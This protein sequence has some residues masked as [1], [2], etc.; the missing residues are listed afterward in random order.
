MY[1]DIKLTG[2]HFQVTQRRRRDRVDW[3]RRH[4]SVGGGPRTARRAVRPAVG[5][6]LVIGRENRLRR[7]RYLIVEH[8]RVGRE[9]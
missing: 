8:G 9:R 5:G 6:H 1:Y 4:R 2:T 7:R 3:R